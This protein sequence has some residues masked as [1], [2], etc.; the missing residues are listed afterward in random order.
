[1]AND[2][3]P[4]GMD[5]SAMLK[6]GRPEVSGNEPTFDHEIEHTSDGTPAWGAPPRGPI[7]LTSFTES[8]RTRG[9]YNPEAGSFDP[10]E[11]TPNLL[12]P[13]LRD[14]RAHLFFVN[15]GDEPTSYVLDL[16]AE[17]ILDGRRAH[18]EASFSIAMPIRDRV[19]ATALLLM[20]LQVLDPDA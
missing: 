6:E 11:G 17:Q 18:P 3:T 1:M 10:P 20:A 5:D 7:D 15:D 19:L 12:P 16:M 9:E 14:G 13:H 2:L 8:A 4:S